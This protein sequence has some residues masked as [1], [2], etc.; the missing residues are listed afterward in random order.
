MDEELSKADWEK[1]VLSRHRSTCANCGGSDK[2]RPRLIVPEEN[3]GKFVLT[4]GVALCRACD[5]VSELKS[6]PDDEKRPVNIWISSDLHRWLK[7]FVEDAGF[8]SISGFVRN[9]LEVFNDSP[10]RFEDLDLYQDDG[11]DVKLNLWLSKPAFDRFKQELDERGM[12]IT[13]GIKS[14]MK[15]HQCNLNRRG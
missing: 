9:L 5:M 15:L 10:D 3:G 11:S 2:V 7:A 14:L 12:T 13:D 6:K 8:A 1:L 4:N